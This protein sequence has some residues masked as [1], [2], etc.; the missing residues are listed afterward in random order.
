MDYN[1]KYGLSSDDI[2]Y[3]DAQID[4]ANVIF[5]RISEKQDNIK[6]GSESVCIERYLDQV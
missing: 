1:K 4:I 3:I 6:D 5:K 2:K